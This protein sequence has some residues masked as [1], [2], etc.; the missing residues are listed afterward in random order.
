M[1]NIFKKT[2]VALCIALLCAFLTSLSAMAALE[3]VVI[4]RNVR[5]NFDG[6]DF[7]FWIQ[8]RGEE[9]AMTLTGGGTFECW[10]DGVLNVLFRMG[11]RLGSVATYEEYGEVILEYA[12][13]YELLGGSVFY[14]C[15]YGW[16][17]NPLVEWYIIESRGSYKPPGGAALGFVEID[18]G[19]YEIFE[20][21]RTNMPSIEGDQTFQQYWSVRTENRSEGT[22]TISDHFKA[23]EEYGMDMSGNMYEVALCIEGFRSSGNAKVTRHVLKIGDEVYGADTLLL[24]GEDEPNAEDDTPGVPSEDTD[25]PNITEPIVTGGNNDDSGNDSS[26]PIVPV[27]AG[28]AAVV[29]IGGA[30]TAISVKR[31]K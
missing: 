31:R 10:W 29:V 19:T 2:S 9:A 16:T 23:W 26:F 3:P 28:G 14:L 4:D 27:I 18:G 21:T 7:E 22:I 12:A 11:K 8:N 5:S 17:Q 15:V 25:Q 13:E 1:K 20:S 30:V 6:F 24:T